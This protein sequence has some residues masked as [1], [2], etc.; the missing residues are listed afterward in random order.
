MVPK[1]SKIKGMNSSSHGTKR[2]RMGQEAQNKDASMTQQPPRRYRL[3]WVMEQEEQ[4]I[5]K[6]VVNFGPRYDPK[7]LDV[8]KTKVRMNGVAE[9]QLQ[10]V[11]MDYPLSEHS[12]ALCRIGPGFRSPLM[13]MMLLMRSTLR[14]TLIWS[15]MVMM[16]MT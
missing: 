5:D 13:M 16:E 12:R 8:T 1:F 15:L 9:E 11:N 10:Q 6:E 7:G 2:S 4:Q 14:L 3:C